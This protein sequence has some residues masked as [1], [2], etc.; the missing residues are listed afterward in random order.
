MRVREAK[1][2]LVEQIRQQA[3][4]ENVQVSPVEIGML[5][6]TE[7]GELSEE[8]H[9][10]SE[11]FDSSYN[12]AEYEKKISQLMKHAY[13]RIRKNDSAVKENWD[14]AIRVLRRGDHYVLVMWGGAHSS[15][16]AVAAILISGVAVVFGLGWV[17]RNVRPPNPQVIW[18]LLLGLA[19]F[20]LFFQRAAAR[21]FNFV[22]DK[23]VA[24]GAGPEGKED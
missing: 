13:T 23:I 5:Y 18:A 15:V 20:G 3:A 7:R 12:M 21:A 10:L 1:D 14:Q 24:F 6:F 19:V 22:A 9:R 11:E 8:M 16:Q 2:F 4:M 17:S